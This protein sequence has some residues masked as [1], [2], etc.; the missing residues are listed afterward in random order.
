MS[1]KAIAINGEERGGKESERRL[2]ISMEY[3]NRYLFYKIH[4]NLFNFENFVDNFLCVL[5]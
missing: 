3:R 2:K 1:S 5:Q 4:S